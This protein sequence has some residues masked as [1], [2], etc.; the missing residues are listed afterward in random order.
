MDIVSTYNAPMDVFDPEMPERAPGLHVS[1]IIAELAQELYPK[2]FKK[3]VDSPEDLK[4]HVGHFEKGLVLE[5][6]WGASLAQ[7][8]GGPF[9]RPIP[10]QVD[11][12]WGSADGLCYEIPPDLV[13]ARVRW[14]EGYPDLVSPSIHECK[15]TLKSCNELTSPIESEKYLTWIWQVKAY[16]YMWKCHVAY[17]HTLH[18]CGDYKARPWT[19]M[20]AVHRIDFTAG[21][22][23]A[24][25]NWLL[26]EARNRGLFEQAEAL[27][28]AAAVTH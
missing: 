20:A 3:W 22:I 17:I 9:S 12:V 7:M 1:T 6:A 4:R 5:H 23:A 24:H 21:E 14:P 26:T 27:D 15:M 2:W 19:P 13:Q 10:K 11:G 16:C 25:W 28:K 8:I 18:I